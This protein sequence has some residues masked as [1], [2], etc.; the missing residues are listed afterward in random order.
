[1]VM[2]S[3]EAI[4]PLPNRASDRNGHLTFLGFT[5]RRSVASAA[6]DARIPNAIGSIKLISIHDRSDS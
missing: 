3:F 6:F 5:D 4:E 2:P 1:M